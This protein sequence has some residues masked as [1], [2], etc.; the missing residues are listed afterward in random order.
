MT[1][2]RRKLGDDLDPRRSNSDDCHSFP[3]EVISFIPVSRMQQLSFEIV[4]PIDIRVLPIAVVMLV[5]RQDPAIGKQN[6]LQDSTSIDEDVAFIREDIVSVFN[7]Q[8][9]LS[10]LLVP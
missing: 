7:G 5:I 9:P 2:T 1:P 3:R 6:S 10:I 8:I 4:N